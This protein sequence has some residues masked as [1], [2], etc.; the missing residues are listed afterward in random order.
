MSVRK[1]IWWSFTLWVLSMMAL[2]ATLGWGFTLIAAAIDRQS[3][4]T[5]CTDMIKMGTARDRLKELGCLP[6]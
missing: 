5:A 3:N 1:F 6:E 2:C 4:M